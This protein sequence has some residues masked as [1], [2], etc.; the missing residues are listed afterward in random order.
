MVAAMAKTVT[1]QGSVREP[2]GPEY[3]Y[4]HACGAHWT[5]VDDGV[6]AEAVVEPWLIH[7]DPQLVADEIDRVIDKK[8]KRHPEYLDFG[9]CVWLT[10]WVETNFCPS[11]MV[12][13]RLERMNVQRGPF[14]KI[15]V[16]CTTRA[17]VYDSQGVTYH[18]DFCGSWPR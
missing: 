16:G 5:V 9:Q 13:T 10:I 4:L 11:P 18:L 1:P 17:L 2:F 14:E 8:A 12:L 3:P 6:P 7:T 15:V